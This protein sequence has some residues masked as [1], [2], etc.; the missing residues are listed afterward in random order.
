MLALPE[1][2]RSRALTWVLDVDPDDELG[3]IWSRIARA[4]TSGALVSVGFGRDLYELRDDPAAVWVAAFAIVHGDDPV[5][6]SL[7][8]RALFAR[9]G[10]ELVDPVERLAVSGSPGLRLPLARSL[11]AAAGDTGTPAGLR[12]RLRASAG[13]LA[14][15]ERARAEADQ[16]LV[17]LR[18]GSRAQAI[19][20]LVR[21]W[22]L[23]RDPA[24]VAL[25]RTLNAF[26]GP[27]P[28][29]IDVPDTPDAPITPVHSEQLAD[30]THAC[31]VLTDERV[32]TLW[33]EVYRRPHD[34]TPRHVLADLYTEL[35]DPR[36]AFISG[37]LR[38]LEMGPEQPHRL[39]GLHTLLKRHEREWLGSFYGHTSR[40]RVWKG[41]VLVGFRSPGLT[42]FGMDRPEWRVIEQV[43][44]GW[45]TLSL[46][47]LTPERLPS[48]RV[49]G[50]LDLLTLEGFAAHPLVP[51]LESIYVRA[52]RRFP[53]P[54]ESRALA[55]W[56]WPEKLVVIAAW[57]LPDEAMALLAGFRLATTFNQRGLWPT[58]YT[59]GP[60]A[61]RC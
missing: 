47:Q 57:P 48:L 52:S 60:A 23:S 46:P 17:A 29:Q 43:D 12:V 15:A 25:L 36:G 3:A 39:R 35:G 31:R 33:A 53:Q 11:I 59:P 37:S 56:A 58:E 4:H 18:E 24:V 14:P 34:L 16:A 22:A 6:M 32:S 26:G 2:V 10:E 19:A 42:G 49:L 20:A 7:T 27:S 5:A 61:P 38:E 54:E 28:A 8:A 21:L 40:P 41:G 55:D 30:L 45:T 9:F 1:S 50:T 44:V 13:R 51:Q